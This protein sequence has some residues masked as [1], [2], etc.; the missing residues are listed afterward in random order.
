MTSTRSRST[1]VREDEALRLPRPP[2]V[3]RRFWARH[4]VLADVLIALVC[5][6]LSLVPVGVMTRDLPMPLAVGVAILVPASVTVAC[7]T[8]LWRRRRPL[9]PF[10]ASFALEVGFLFALQPIGSPLLFVACYSLA[11]YR[12]SRAAWIGFGSGLAALAALGGSLTLTGVITFQIAVNAVLTWLVLGLIGTLT[13]VNVGGRKRYLAAVIDR[14]RQLLVERDQQAQL[15][16]ADE[17]ARIAREMHDIVSH[18]LT[19]IVALSEG[20]AATP[21]REQAR[22]AAASAAETA[23]SALTEMRAMLGVLRSD[24]SPLPLAPLA[25]TPPHETVEQAQRAGFPVTLSVS[26]GEYLSPAAS[27]AVGRIVQEGVTNAMRHAPAATSIAV[28]LSY[29]SDAVTIE[30]VNDGVRGA[31][32]T[33]GFG[34]R[35]LAERAAHAGG[36]LVS[37]PFDDGRRWRLRAELPVSAPDMTSPAQEEPKDTP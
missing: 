9:V 5:L 15:A 14:S 30:V 34:L 22:A 37:E 18:S 2:G 10:V 21:D 25:P 12:S 35:G 3:L 19:V 29:T 1:S 26:G 13:G 16:A 24:D 33:A 28:R 31:V 17:R 23:R 32:G 20:S 7:A 4:P 6:L 8:L 36:V 27:H 11:V